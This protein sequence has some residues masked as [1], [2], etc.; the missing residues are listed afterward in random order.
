MGQVRA[1]FGAV[2]RNRDLRRVELA[3]AGF[4]AA[5]YGVWIAMLV[6]AYNQGGATA[7][8]VVVIVQ[9]VPATLFAPI[10]GVLADRYPAARVQAA[11]YLAQAAGMGATG[12]SLLLGGPPALSYA[13]AA[14][15]ATAVTITRPTQAVLAPALARSP[16]E[17]TA[18][19]VVSGWIESAAVLAGPALTGVLLGFTT[20]GVVFLV[21]AAVV[22]VSAALVAP[23]APGFRHGPGEEAETVRAEAHSEVLA[24]FQALRVNPPARLIVLFLVAQDVIFGAL[25][26]LFVVLAISVLELGD[27]GAGYLNAAFGAGGVIAALVTVH[28]VGRRHLVP[29]LIAASVVWGAAF[30]ILGVRPTTVGAIVLITLAGLAR[31]VFDVSGRTLLQRTAPPDVLCRVFGVLEGLTMAMLAVGAII[32]P[33]LVALG[34]ATLAF[35]VTGALLPVL[36]LV[37]LRALRRV[38][39]AATVPI[40][41][42]SL[43][44]SLRIF[45]PLPAPAI[46][47]L[48]HSLLPI[49][50]PAGTVIVR[51]GDAGDRFYAIAD[52]ELEVIQDGRALRRLGRGDGFGEI[53]LLREVP[54]TASVTATKDSSLYALEKEPFVIALTGHR[55]ATET[56]DEIIR[57]HSGA[58][59]PA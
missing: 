10:G 5:E 7:A 46:E 9:L 3:F 56:A 48:A 36:V 44:R 16:D 54:R 1:V 49:D 18:V 15:A 40:V 42:I 45:R 19:N 41:E 26:V 25:D 20:A 32:V 37:R 17:L 53:A 11:G 52:G 6:Y 47:G 12:V 27:A 39:A 4:N 55:P 30:V 2:L 14:V 43:L 23:V 31:S 58:G 34:G 51:Q 24:G 8:G 21:F 50:A 29:P 22:L 35:I 38:D 57:E 13:L 28:L 59:A 33:P